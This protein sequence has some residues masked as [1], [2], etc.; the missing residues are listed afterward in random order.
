MRFSVVIPVY[1]KANT[2]MSAIDSVLAQTYR[3]FE[4]VVVN[5]GS[6]DDFF[7]VQSQLQTNPLI[8]IISQ[9]NGGV[10]VARNTG[11]ENSQGDFICFLDADDL[12][13]DNHLQVLSDM[14][15]EFPSQSFFVT[16]GYVILPNGQKVDRANALGDIE[17]AFVCD[18][19]FKLLNEKND[20]LINTNSVCIR[21]S[22]FFDEEIF[23]EKGVKLGEDTDVWY[24]ISL[25]HS[26]VV[27][28]K[29]TTTYRQTFSTAT[30][31][32]PSNIGWIFA[33]RFREF[34]WEDIKPET[35]LECEKLIDRYLM[36]CSR[37]YLN[38]ADKKSA[39]KVL[40]QVKYKNFKYFLSWLLCRFPLKLSQKI[41]KSI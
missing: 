14:I 34:T 33:K 23:F 40:K 24:R 31:G 6:T 25:K 15:E 32:S 13:E 16:Q 20:G 41:I 5:D 10:S 26:V 21:K 29:K 7:R 30:A 39:K 1:N 8:K 22:L 2:L 17:N 18:N 11:I 28:P 19:L 3:D 12:Y 9:E 27:S 37:D 35:K 4:I 36:A 38:M